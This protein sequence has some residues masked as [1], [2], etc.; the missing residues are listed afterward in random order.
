MLARQLEQVNLQEAISEQQL[1]LQTLLGGDLSAQS[2]S[3]KGIR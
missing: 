2:G 3:A 1:V